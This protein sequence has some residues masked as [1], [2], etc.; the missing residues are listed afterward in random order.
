MA[1][2]WGGR[3][4]L[5][6][7][8]IFVVLAAVMILGPIPAAIAQ[9]APPAVLVAPAQ[10]ENV[11]NTATFVGRVKAVDKVEL[12]ARVSGYLGPRLFKEGDKVNEGQT[13]FTLDPAPFEAVLGQRRADVA[14][15][16]AA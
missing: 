14:A 12:R 2:L 16:T 7:T 5:H 1:K 9:P 3:L 4:R 6:A 15:A 10:L 13:V 11:S 8:S